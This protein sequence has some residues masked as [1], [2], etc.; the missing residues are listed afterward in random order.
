M[1]TST[2][3]PYTSKKNQ[4]CYARFCHHT[5]P[6]AAG[7]LAFVTIPD[8]EGIQQPL[9]ERAELKDTL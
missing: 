9:L 2:K 3:V 6:K 4:Q 7:G 1:L 8:H 5:K